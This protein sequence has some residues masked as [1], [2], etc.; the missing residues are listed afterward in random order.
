MLFLHNE[1]CVNNLMGPRLSGEASS[2]TAA[3]DFPNTLWTPK[4]ITVFTRALHWA[5]WIQSLPPHLFSKIY[6]NSIHLCIGLPSGLFPSGFPTKVVYA[7]LLT[8]IRA[9]CPLFH[10]PWLDNPLHTRQSV[11]DTKLH[12]FFQL[13]ITSSLFGPNHLAIEMSSL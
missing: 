9:T 13:S 7:F 5:K 11:Q 8:P 6:F 4:V 3:Q 10:L 2:C 1:L 12:S